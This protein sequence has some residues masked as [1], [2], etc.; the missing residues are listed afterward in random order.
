MEDA[1]EN[2]AAEQQP[3]LHAH[4]AAVAG[5]AP[6]GWPALD[7]AAPCAAQLRRPYVR[8]SGSGPGLVA[9]SSGLPLCRICLEEDDPSA[10]EAPCRCAGTQRF[11]HPQC[12]QRWVDEKGN[13]TCEICGTAYRGSYTP[14]PPR[15][16][17]VHRLTRE[18]RI[19]LHQ[20]LSRLAGDA[21]IA[22]DDGGGRGGGRAGDG[23]ER[24][25]FSWSATLATCALFLL[26]IH[27][28]LDAG[29]PGGAAAGAAGPGAGAAGAEGFAPQ[30]GA[31]GGMTRLDEAGPVLSAG[32]GLALAVG[33][34]LLALWLATKLLLMTVPLLVMARMWRAPGGPGDGPALR[35]VAV[36]RSG[37]GAA[38]AAGGAGGVG[39]GAA[40][41]AVRSAVELQHLGGGGGGGGDPPAGG[42][43]GA[44][45]PFIIA[46][47]ALSRH[48][49]RRAHHLHQPGLGAAAAE[50]P[51]A[52]GGGDGGGAGAAAAAGG[53]AGGRFAGMV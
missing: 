2:A 14:P 41:V 24:P 21:P 46:L 40:V 39:G 28:S 33:L 26:L 50:G 37:G 12:I 6:A 31:G 18:E 22:S 10:L 44:R 32:A 30:P 13:L 43:A 49:L 45:H 1:P 25:G 29:A 27:G 3:L 11:A 48:E 23:E 19:A 52:R 4:A 16:P 38:A 15:A 36:A 47:H 51:A 7:A 53:M 35:V 8:A 42:D 9:Q 17:P 5:A 20:I 34:L